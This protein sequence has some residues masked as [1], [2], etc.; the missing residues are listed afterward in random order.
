MLSFFNI[1][2]YTIKHFSQET[3]KQDTF[4]L[5]PTLNLLGVIQE[6]LTLG[7][8]LNSVCNSS[9]KT[10]MLQFYVNGPVKAKYQSKYVKWHI[11]LKIEARLLSLSTNR[12][13]QYVF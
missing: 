10:E 1:Q 13:V 12:L 3:E 8:G 2:A 11:K 6:D 4:T 5:S 9:R 7:A